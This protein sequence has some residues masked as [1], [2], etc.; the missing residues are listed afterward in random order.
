MVQDLSLAALTEAQVGK[1][2]EYGISVRYTF[3][4]TDTNDATC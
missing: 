1:T 2:V 4:A 3:L